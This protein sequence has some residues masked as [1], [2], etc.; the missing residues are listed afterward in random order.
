MRFMCFAGFLDTLYMPLKQNMADFPIL[1]ISAHRWAGFKC[2]RN[3]LNLSKII[4]ANLY[5]KTGEG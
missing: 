1:F 3:F 5:L 4:A 2:L